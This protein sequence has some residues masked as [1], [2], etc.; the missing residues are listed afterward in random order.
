MMLVFGKTGQVATELRALLPNA[1][2]LGREQADLTEPKACFDAILA[3]RPEAVIN[4]AAYTAVDYAEENEATADVVNGVAPVQMAKACAELDIPLVHISTDYVFD[5]SGV[6]PFKPGDITAP[7][8]AYGR[9][10]LVG[11]HGVTE[12]GGRSAILRTSWVFSA[13][14]G[15]FV[16]TMLRYGET[17]DKLT[18]V[19][20]QIGGPTAA[21]DI[22]KACVTIARK[23]KVYPDKAGIYHFSGAPDVSWAD[24]AREIFAQTG[25]KVV[26]EGIPATSYPT[27]AARPYNSRMDCTSFEAAFGIRR[28][29]W[30]AG[31][32]DVLSD[33]EK[34]T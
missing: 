8:C 3:A 25:K 18:V 14:G 27:P 21:C 20:D 16:K 13:H 5:G 22:A 9:T 34:T 6:V 31:L 1:R 30:K 10:K 2:F 23:L 28:P 12:V 7:L 32:A 26:V 4:A 17:R 24:F 19:A 29:D 33:L 15:N 11:E